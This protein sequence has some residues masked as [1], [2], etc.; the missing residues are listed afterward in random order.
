MNTLGTS[1]VTLSQTYAGLSHWFNQRKV[2]PPAMMW[3][4]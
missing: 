3:E 2:Q 1:A 4:E